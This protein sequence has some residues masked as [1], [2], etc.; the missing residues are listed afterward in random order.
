MTYPFLKFELNKILDGQICFSFL[1]LKKAGIDFGNT[2]ILN[3][4]DLDDRIMGRM[5]WRCFKMGGVSRKYNCL[6]YFL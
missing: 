6:T 2:I 5:R 1:N 3:H 4:P